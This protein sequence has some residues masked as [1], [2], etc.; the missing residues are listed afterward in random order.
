MHG[1]NIGWWKRLAARHASIK[2]LAIHEHDRKFSW[3]PGRRPDGHP[4]P[5]DLGLTN[6]KKRP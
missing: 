3:P 1:R 5:S 6:Q 4:S 2:D